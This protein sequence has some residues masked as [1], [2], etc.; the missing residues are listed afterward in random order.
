MSQ[1]INLD[2]TPGLFMPTL[3]YSQGDVGREYTLNL[4]TRDGSDIPTGVTATL[5]FTKPSGFGVS[6]A[7]T[8]SGSVVTFTT[9]ETM[10]NENGKVDAQIRLTKSGID[11]GTARFWWYGEKRPHPDGT[12]DGDAESEIPTLTLLVERI[13]AAADS[14]HDLSVEANTLAYSADATATYDSGTNKITF[15]IPR[16]GAMAVTDTD[17]DGN[18]VITFD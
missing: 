13:E 1:T 16:G 9:T 2:L 18:I 7:V 17:S 10:T 5:E 3:Y 4:S 14:I 12:T 15:G 11:I 8:I 6:E